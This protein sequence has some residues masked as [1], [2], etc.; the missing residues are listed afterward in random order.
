MEKFFVV[1]LTGVAI[2]LVTMVLSVA[3]AAEPEEITIVTKK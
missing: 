2:A 3:S 1:I